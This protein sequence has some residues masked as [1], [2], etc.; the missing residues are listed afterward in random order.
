LVLQISEAL[1]AAYAKGIIHDDLKPDNII[2]PDGIKILD[3]GL[4]RKVTAEN[5][6][7]GGRLA[8][9]LTLH[10]SRAGSWRTPHAKMIIKRDW[11][12]ARAR[13]QQQVRPSAHGSPSEE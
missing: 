12:S 13:L 1:A 9:T 8:D 6:A 4:A 2:R 10:V 7:T 3:F 5:I 11:I